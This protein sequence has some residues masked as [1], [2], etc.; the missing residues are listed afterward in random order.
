[1]ER[2]EPNDLAPQRLREST[3]RLSEVTLEEL[4]DGLGEI[5]L[6]GSVDD[7]LLRELVRDHELGE[8]SY[9]LR[10][11]SDLDDVSTLGRNEEKKRKE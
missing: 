2:D 4:D 7:V 8:V 5:E 10:R 11:G 9:D 3:V 1:M 6:V